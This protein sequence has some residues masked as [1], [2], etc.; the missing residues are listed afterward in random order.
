MLPATLEKIGYALF[1]GCVNIQVIWVDNGSAVDDL[2]KAHSAAILLGRSTMVGDKLLRDFRRL[3][4]VI[5]PEGVLEIGE[6]WF[7]NSEVE[8][9]T[10]PASVAAIGRDAF[11][12]YKC[13]KHVIFTKETD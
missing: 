12:C 8:S 4:D 3:K 6:Q 9:V 11:C 2:R 10:I 13:L 5:I 7:M 1:F